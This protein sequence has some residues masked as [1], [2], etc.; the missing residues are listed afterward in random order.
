MACTFL[1]V[2]AGGGA[3]QAD[4]GKGFKPSSRK[5]SVVLLLRCRNRLFF[6]NFLEVGDALGGVAQ[7]LLVYG[8]MTTS[9]FR[10]S[11]SSLTSQA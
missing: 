11:I 10:V 4:Y 8:K 3:G 9:R 7:L 5:K 6:G 2:A 1:A